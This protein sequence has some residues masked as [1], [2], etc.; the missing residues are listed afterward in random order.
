MNRR[1]RCE[2]VRGW[3]VLSSHFSPE[4]APHVGQGTASVSVRLSSSAFL[5]SAALSPSAYVD[6]SISRTGPYLHDCR[7]ACFRKP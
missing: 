2:L 4:A 5:V 7:A 6:V 3:P 1:S